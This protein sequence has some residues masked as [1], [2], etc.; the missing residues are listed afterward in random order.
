MSAQFVRYTLQPWLRVWEQALARTLFTPKERGKLYFEFDTNDF[1]KADI[2]ARFDAYSGAITNG[3]LNPNEVRALENRPPYEGGD[4][5]WMP[6][7]IEAANRE[8]LNR[9]VAD[10]NAHLSA[11]PRRRRETQ[12]G[13]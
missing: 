13:D 12:N 8:R 3:F 11:T 5:F 1:V 4:Q 2:A 7:N 10:M 9:G 6:S